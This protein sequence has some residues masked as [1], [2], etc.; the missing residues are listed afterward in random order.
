[1]MFEA[2]RFTHPLCIL[3]YIILCM[4]VL[5]RHTIRVLQR[6]RESGRIMRPPS[7]KRIYFS[8]VKYISPVITELKK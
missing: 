8:I 6:H 1:M 2:I 7:D 4:C 5:Q 3:Y